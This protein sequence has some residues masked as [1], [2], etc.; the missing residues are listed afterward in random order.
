MVT[1]SEHPEV[2]DVVPGTTPPPKPD[3]EGF[4]IIRVAAFEP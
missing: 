3:G 2:F 4:V 1:R